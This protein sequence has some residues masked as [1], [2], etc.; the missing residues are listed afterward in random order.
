MPEFF[1]LLFYNTDTM[2]DIARSL[3]DLVGKTPLVELPS[4]AARHGAL[5]RIYAK[6]EYLNPSGSVKD[7]AALAMVADAERRGLLQPGG[8]IIEPTSGNTGI[9]LAMVATARGYRLVIAMPE[10]MSAERIAILRARGAEVI[11]TPGKLGMQGAID[12]A[13]ELQAATPG[14]FI[15]GQ[16]TNPANPEAHYLGTGV[17][18][19]DD[20]AGGVDI[21]VAGVGTGGTVSGVGRRLKERKPSVRIVAVEPAESPVLSGGQPGPHGIQGIGAGFVP[22]VYD[23]TVVDEIVQVATPDAYALKHEAAV[24]GLF[25]GISSGAALCAALQLARREE[26]RNKTIVVLL[27]DSGDKYLSLDK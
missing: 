4:L 9:G 18:I 10:T 11:L 12:K 24:E 16:F 1:V 7:R 14:A 15:P 21:F 25:V 27:P 5:A 3:T 26:N 6:L 19:W 22:G 8:V 23:P 2:K 20:T 13:H 17:E